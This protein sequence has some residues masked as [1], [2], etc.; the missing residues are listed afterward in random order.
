MTPF[1]LVIQGGTVA[2]AVDTFV[3]DIGITDGKI[4]AL[5]S[6][7]QSSG[8]TIDATGKYVLPGGVES[9]CHIAQESSF[10]LMASDD[11]DS[12]SV[13]AAFGGNTTIIPFAAQKR[14]QSLGE[15]L[16]IYHD[17]AAPKS[18]IDYSFHL[19]LSDPTDSVL[20]T[21]LPAAFEQGI[22][23]F[24][25]FM[26]YDLMKIDDRQMLDVLSIAREYGA[27]T[28]VHAEND[29]LIK[30]VSSR[31]LERGYRDPKYHAVS[32]PRVAESE[33]V[34]RATQLATFIDAPMLVVHISTE[35]AARVIAEARYSGNKI[36]GETCPHYLFLTSNHMDMPGPEA[37]KFCC[38]PPLRDAE[39]QAHMW[40][41]LQNGT[42]QLI[43]SDHAP[44]RFDE[45]GKL[46]AGPNPSFKECANGVPG[47]ELRMPLMFSEG[48]R[49]QRISLNQFVALTST[50]AAKLFGLHPKKGTI[51]VG[52]DADIAI[53]DP[54]LERT[55]S[56]EMLHDNMNY[57]PYDGFKVTGWPVTVINRGRIVVESNEL[58]VER[59]SG[60]FLKRNPTDLTGMPGNVA[61]ELNP[62][63]NFGTILR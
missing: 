49:K 27:L 50:N 16:D 45:T 25:V 26:T 8:K 23:S 46:S 63:K 60:K 4:T 7:L 55:V 38:S 39:T 11:Y 14:G 47:I 30:W 2:T 58:K 3:A 52:A 48:V 6:K 36:Y 56:S 9:H 19:I 34:H 42:F 51:A 53:W 62:E 1:D 10:G 15:V 22:L 61:P 24:K 18:V 20:K 33:A 29:A 5:G 35:K 12:G 13:S 44:Y 40:Q 43:S 31:L 17:R 21:E 54:D 32:H 41:A 28:M 59:G 37:A 57:T